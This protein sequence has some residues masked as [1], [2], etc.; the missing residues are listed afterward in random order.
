MTHEATQPRAGI[1]G[2]GLMRRRW[3]RSSE[4]I[5]RRQEPKP[6]QGEE[7][8]RTKGAQDQEVN[9][10][11]RV[12][13]LKAALQQEELS[14]LHVQQLV[15]RT[16]LWSWQQLEGKWV[17]P[18]PEYSP[19][20]SYDL[21]RASIIKRMNFSVRQLPH[22]QGRW[23]RQACW[24][25]LLHREV[26][27]TSVM[28]WRHHRSTSALPQTGTDCNHYPSSFS[29]LPERVYMKGFS[30]LYRAPVQNWVWVQFFVHIDSALIKIRVTPRT[31][32]LN[33]K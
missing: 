30:W 10:N 8:G 21:I 11:S 6:P 7:E 15:W 31:W 27:C 4:E 14:H 26:H 32:G 13:N 23:Q 28:V 22:M 2:P 12:S 5:L 33:G 9:V 1:S 18:S 17:L 29:F 24:W 16:W 20:T 19:N 3:R 25:E